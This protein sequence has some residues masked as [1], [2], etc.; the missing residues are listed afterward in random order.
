[1]IL[2]A[3]VVG[4]F[5][6]FT[7]DSQDAPAKPSGRP[8]AVPETLIGLSHAEKALAS[9]PNQAQYLDRVRTEDRRSGE[10]LS[11]AYGGAPAFWQSYSAK[12]FGIQLQ[13]SAVR[14]SSPRLMLRYLDLQAIRQARPQE[15]V[16]VH[17]DVDCMVINSNVLDED[18][19]PED[20]RVMYC[21]R[22]SPYLTVRI[23]VHTDMS[24][25][26]I[27]R[28]EATAALVNQIWADL[29]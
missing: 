28:P 6:L 3:A 22:S 17:G 8:L 18:I 12:D 4:A 20:V 26:Y 13:L 24:D 15:E 21:Q 16:V 27:H 1:M 11:Q 2:G 25:T 23:T 10:L 5:W 9:K 14:A 19:K 7:G 29:N